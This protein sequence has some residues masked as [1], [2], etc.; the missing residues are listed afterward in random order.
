MYYN[1]VKSDKA[2]VVVGTQVIGLA[3]A[4]TITNRYYDSFI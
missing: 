1:Y 3:T 2:T 4:I